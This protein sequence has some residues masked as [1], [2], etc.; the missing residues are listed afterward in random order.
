MKADNATLVRLKLDGS[1]GIPPAEEKTFKELA[2]EVVFTLCCQYIVDNA[3]TVMV[4]VATG[5]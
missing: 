3:D 5:G 1:P 4:S 2:P